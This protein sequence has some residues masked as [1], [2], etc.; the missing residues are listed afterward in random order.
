MSNTSLSDFIGAAAKLM[1]ADRPHLWES[2][3]EAVRDITIA[4]SEVS[5][6]DEDDWDEYSVHLSGFVLT[7]IMLDD[8]VFEYTLSKKLVSLGIFVDDEESHVHDWTT[9]SNLAGGI[10]LNLPELDEEL[11]IESDISKDILYEDDD[12]D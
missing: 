9:G 5:D 6:L 3:E 8:G 7:R 12:E 11:D 1:R 4:F 2:H 10:Q